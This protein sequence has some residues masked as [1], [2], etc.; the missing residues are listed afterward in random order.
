[1]RSRMVATCIPCIASSSKVM[2][3]QRTARSAHALHRLL[4]GCA[5]VHRANPLVRWLVALTSAYTPARIRAEWRYTNAS[6]RTVAYSI[7][8]KWHAPCSA[9]L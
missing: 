2:H 5:A 9:A 6:D 4:D 8:H 3:G 7:W 1:M